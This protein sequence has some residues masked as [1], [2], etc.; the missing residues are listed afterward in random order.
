MWL[1]STRPPTRS[2]CYHCRCDIIQ[3]S[4]HCGASRCVRKRAVM[5]LHPIGTILVSGNSLWFCRCRFFAVFCFS[6]GLYRRIML[7]R[8]QLFIQC[9]KAGV[10][11]L[12]E[13]CCTHIA[14]LQ[15]CYSCETALRDSVG[16]RSNVSHNCLSTKDSEFCA[17]VNCSKAVNESIQYSNYKTADERF[18]SA[19]ML[20][21][22]H[23]L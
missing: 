3:G 14:Q 1:V 2:W 10:F 5:I 19:E 11:D 13:A 12:T 7:T 18:K 8:Y 22:N 23:S 6:L 9:S 17:K 16:R 15:K 20:E 4:S 21:A